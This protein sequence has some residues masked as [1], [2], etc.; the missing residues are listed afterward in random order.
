MKKTL[1]EWRNERGMSQEDLA[2]KLDVS[3]WSVVR[4]ES[5]GFK[6]AKF[7]TVMK[8]LKELDIKL[9]QL[10]IKQKGSTTND[11][12]NKR[13]NRLFHSG[14]N[15]GSSIFITDVSTTHSILKEGRIENN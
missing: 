6:S 8:I 3:T 2:R 5:E 10:E 15:H 9:N 12:T 14:W 7:G 13:I 11:K 1:K 4:Y